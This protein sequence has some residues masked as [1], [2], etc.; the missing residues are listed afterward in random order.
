MGFLHIVQ[1]VHLN[2]FPRKDLIKKKKFKSS[3]IWIERHRL[4]NCVCFRIPHYSLMDMMNSCL[5]SHEH[6][7]KETHPAV[8]ISIKDL[9]RQGFGI[10]RLLPHLILQIRAL[11]DV[12]GKVLDVLW[13]EE[14]ED[15]V[16]L[17]LY[18]RVDS[19]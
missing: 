7:F 16:L 17:L 5:H 2:S 1:P 19:V 15:C 14:P 12:L 13:I 3:N 9:R 18:L 6:V 8:F 10:P 11:S 4:V